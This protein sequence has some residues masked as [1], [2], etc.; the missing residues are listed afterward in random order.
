M[1]E[2]FNVGEDP[3]FGPPHPRAVDY[4]RCGN[5]S[6][7][8]GDVVAVDGRFYACASTGWAALKDRPLI[9]QRRTHGT[10]PLPAFGLST[11]SPRIGS[12]P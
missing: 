5:R 11:G 10:T 8:V 2:L 12:C 3:A 4:R 9:D 1:F 7:S 6:L